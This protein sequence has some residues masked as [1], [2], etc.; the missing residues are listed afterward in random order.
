MQRGEK[1]SLLHKKWGEGVGV[2]EKCKYYAL[3]QQSHGAREELRVAA[4]K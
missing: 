1:G 3:L 4:G 2:E